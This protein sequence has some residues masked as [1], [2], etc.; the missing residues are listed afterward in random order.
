MYLMYATFVTFQIFM[1][2]V[3][4]WV[5]NLLINLINILRVYLHL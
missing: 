2:P 5:A 1:M 3:L 4:F